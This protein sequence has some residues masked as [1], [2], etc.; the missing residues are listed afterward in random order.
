MPAFRTR[1]RTFHIPSS[2]CS[3]SLYQPRASDSSCCDCLSSTRWD[4]LLRPKPF[5]Q[6]PFPVFTVPLNPALRGCHTECPS[7]RRRGFPLIYLPEPAWLHVSL[8]ID[9][10]LLTWP[11]CHFMSL[12]PDS[13]SQYLEEQISLKLGKAIGLSVTTISR[14]RES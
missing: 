9:L 3:A 8:T 13:V 11:W 1:F 12:D 5:V 2:C 7:G 6:W 4:H 14:W 10:S